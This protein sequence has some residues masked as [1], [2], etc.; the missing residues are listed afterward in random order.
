MDDQKYNKSVLIVNDSADAHMT[1][2]LFHRRDLICWMSSES[3]II[4]P[5]GKYLH[6]SKK[7]FQFKLVAKFEDKRPTKKLLEVQHWNEDKLFKVTGQSGTETPALIEDKLAH[8]PG[9]KQICLRKIHRDK[10]LKHTSRGRNLYEILGLNMDKIRKMPKEEQAKELKKGF[11]T[12]ILIWHPDRN[13]GDDEVFKEI[14]FAYEILKDEEKRA[15]YNNLADYDEDW[16]WFSLKRYKALFWPECVTKEQKSAYRKRMALFAL[17][18]VMAVGGIGLTVFTAGLVAPALVATGAVFGGGLI[19]G[20]LQSLQH[21]LNKNSVVDEFRCKDWLMKAGIGFVGGAVT[22]GAAAGITAAVTGIGGAAMESAAITAG[23]YMGIGAATGA[24]GGVAT[25]LSSDAGRKFVDEEN[26]TWKQVIG[27]ATCGALVG[28]A[29]GLA[30]GAVTKTIVGA[31]SSAASA[32]LEGEIGEQ[33][34]IRTG[35]RRLGNALARQVPRMLTESGTEAVM[36][37]VSQFAEERLDDSM[38][39]RSP[40]E[41][42][43]D[44]AKEVAAKGVRGFARGCGG[45]VLSHAWNEIKVDRR[46]KRELKDPSIDVEAKT[47]GSKPISRS[48]VR[49]TLLKED[50]EDLHKWREGKCS[51]TYEPPVNEEPHSLVATHSPVA[52]NLST[53]FEDAPSDGQEEGEQWPDGKVKYI[54][55]GAWISKMI[56]SFSVDG[57][58]KTEEVRGSGKSIDIPSSA[59]NIEVKF[60][61][62]RPMWGDIVKYDRFQKC[63]CKPYEPH[64]F[65]FDTPQVRTFTISGNLW[66]EAV[67]RVSDEYHEETMEM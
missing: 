47:K 27:H 50:K 20:G 64:V 34:V 35:A 62:S 1:L 22:G 43:T 42:V 24:T 5:G 41:H 49:Y 59:R 7:S 15:R 36:G 56:V 10:E 31:Q 26:I 18:A 25:S 8:Y 67:M 44:A 16:R 19:G 11:R 4:K 6:R 57:E 30:G 23:Q 29:A 66:W 63:W 32:T 40:R 53:I 3:R 38:E 65:R 37:S 61:V 55:E 52:D 28:T 39:N 2:Y 45:A 58:R 13:R 46:L 14:F 48:R 51:A 17:S 54:S 60:R 9:E 21:T 33:I 12:Q